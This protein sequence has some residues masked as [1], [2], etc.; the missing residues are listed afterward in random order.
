M[1]EVSNAEAPEC[2]DLKCAPEVVSLEVGHLSISTNARGRP[3]I[4]L[5]GR[6]EQYVT[7]FK[8]ECKSPQDP[9]LLSLTRL[10]DPRIV[11]FGESNG[12]A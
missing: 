2:E 12:E 4:V 9:I 6:E 11:K 3:V 8:V 10:I 7:A 1:T 5:D